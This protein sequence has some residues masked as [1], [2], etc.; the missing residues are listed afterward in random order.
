MKIVIIATVFL[1]TV[2]CV[3]EKYLAG[4]EQIGAQWNGKY[5][6]ALNGTAYVNMGNK[7]LKICHIEN[8]PNLV[9]DVDKVLSQDPELK[10]WVV[11]QGNYIAIKMTKTSASSQLYTILHINYPVT[12][13]GSFPQTF[14]TNIN[15]IRY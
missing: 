15:M 9:Y 6:E 4:G 8:I 1:M 12:L 2:Y 7:Q 10:T 13:Q 14:D 11:F 3:G 5:S